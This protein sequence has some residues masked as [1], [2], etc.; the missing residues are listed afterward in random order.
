MEPRFFRRNSAPAI[1]APFTAPHRPSAAGQAA[2][3]TASAAASAA[4]TPARTGA[5]P[6]GRP[7]ADTPALG[8]LPGHGPSPSERRPVAAFVAGQR[9]KDKPLKDKP[10][11]DKPIPPGKTATVSR[12]TRLPAA[13]VLRDRKS[14]TPEA[15]VPTLLQRR[16]SVSSVHPAEGLHPSSDAPTFAAVRAWR[17][18]QT[19]ALGKMLQSTPPP[20]LSAAA[21]GAPMAPMARALADDP[22]SL[23]PAL[24]VPYQR[25]LRTYGVAVPGEARPDPMPP[26]LPAAGHGEL[27]ALIAFLTH[28][29]GSIEGARARGLP[30]SMSRL[31][32][33]WAGALEPMLDQARM[34]LAQRAARSP[35]LGSPPPSAARGPLTPVAFASGAALVAGDRLQVAGVR[36][37]DHGQAPG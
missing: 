11:K 14:T 1:S 33:Q 29:I 7:R 22:E 37:A 12:Q 18:R 9:P 21:R 32:R 26:S 27:L 35:G 34:A 8:V 6:S 2:A 17:E 25:L 36:P 3:T 23:L 28:E 13:R 24:L 10:L 4:A 20:S 16:H 15:E 31:Y 19:P 5:G 30:E